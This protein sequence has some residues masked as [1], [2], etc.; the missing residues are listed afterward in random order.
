MQGL[1]DTHTHL[2][3]F[4]KKG[5]LENCL[6]RAAESGI[7]QMITV[8][9][10]SED[11]ELYQ[12][13]SRK[14]SRRIAYT[15]GL[16][17][18]SVQ[19]NWE[20][21]IES[22][23]RF[24]ESNSPRP[25]AVGEIGLDR[26][27]LPAD[28]READTV[29]SRQQAAFSAGLQFAKQMDCPVVIHSRGAFKESVKMINESGINWS[30]VVFHCFSEGPDEI[31]LLNNFGARASFTGILTYKNAQNVRDSALAQ[32]LDKLMLETDAPYLAPAPN[33]GKPNEPSYIKH[34]AE[35]AAQLF[36]VTM[37]ELIS[38]THQEA[39]RFYGIR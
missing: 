33:R 12:N 18:C 30:R 20:Q 38:E 3:S 8:G 2:E 34:T 5:D 25:I 11:W 15:V 37:E 21:E 16:H 17:P 10:S 6:K 39:C 1:I 31:K 27:H 13:I 9:T 4:F 19:E 36:G 35:F 28:P 24:W 29:F 32:G 22:M 26:F 7:S 14:Y 23:L